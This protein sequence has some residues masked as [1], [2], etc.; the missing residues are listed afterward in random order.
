[1]FDK[2]ILGGERKRLNIANE[3]LHEPGVL[4]ADECASRLDSSSAYTVIKFV[5]EL[6][7][8]GRAVFVTI[9]Q[10]SLQ[11]FALF[12]RVMLLAAGRIAFCGRSHHLVAYLATIDFPFPEKAYNPAD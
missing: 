1:M 8:E 7:D 6:C 5:S 4:L 2:G 12:D 10:Q 3:L 9:H 11:M